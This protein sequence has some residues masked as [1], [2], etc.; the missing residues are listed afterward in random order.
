MHYRQI[1]EVLEMEPEK[2]VSSIKS[3]RHLHPGMIFRIAGYVDKEQD[4]SIHQ[5]MP[6]YA[7]E[8]GPDAP[9]RSGYSKE[10]MRRMR[11]RSWK[12]YQAIYSA[13]RHVRKAKKKGLHLAP[14]PW[15]GL[16]TKRAAA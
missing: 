7:A 8:A 10:K 9:K 5:L 12:K 14:N 3:A 16:M 6:L 4:P 11:R 2:V 13:K 15:R 1:A